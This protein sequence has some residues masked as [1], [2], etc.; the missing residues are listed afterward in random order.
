MSCQPA[1]L[2][3]NFVEGE[4]F[5]KASWRTRDFRY[6]Y[7]KID[8]YNSLYQSSGPSFPKVDN[9]IH[10]VKIYPMDGVIPI[11]LPNTYP[12][13]RELSDGQRYLSFE[14]TWHGLLPA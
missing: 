7:I 6:I 4:N 5:A 8:S 12:L 10:G 9:G 14:Q 2:P 11:G 3:I 13:D 1:P